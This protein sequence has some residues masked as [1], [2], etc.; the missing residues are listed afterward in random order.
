MTRP[1]RLVLVAGTATDIGKTW[2]GGQVLDRL[3]AAGTTV[4]ARKPAQ[5][6]DAD[7]PGPSDAAVLAAATGEPVEQVCPPHRWYTVA[8]APPMAAD[9]LGLP[10]PT[11]A[12]LV[13]ELTWPDG[14]ARAVGWV[15]TVGGPRSPI[16]SDGDAVDLAEMLAPDLVVLVADAGLGTVNSVRLGADVFARWPVTVFLN[17]FDPADDLHRRNLDWLRTRERLEVVVDLEAL[18]NRVAGGPTT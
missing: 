1:Q 3:A 17:R 8:M 16:G 18:S 13:A 7:D 11:L 15:E 4:A 12:D 14:P 5:S 9:A 6:A 10:V 2:V